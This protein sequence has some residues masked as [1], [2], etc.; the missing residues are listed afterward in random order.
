MHAREDRNTHS[1]KD[2]SLLHFTC[3]MAGHSVNFSSLEKIVIFFLSFHLIILLLLYL[4]CFYLVP[5]G[6]Q[7]KRTEVLENKVDRMLVSKAFFEW[8]HVKSSTSEGR[9]QCCSS[10][11]INLTQ[12]DLWQ[13]VEHYTLQQAH[14]TV[15]LI[16]QLTVKTQLILQDVIHMSITKWIVVLCHTEQYA[17][18]GLLQWITFNIQAIF[19]IFKWI[20]SNTFCNINSY[21]LIEQYV[22]RKIWWFFPSNLSFLDINSKRCKK[23][24]MLLVSWWKW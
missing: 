1:N 11:L 9:R 4:I 22:T 8:T 14:I 19:N 16:M 7:E 5:K 21:S 23:C 15:L 18:H 6:V 13:Y 12:C 17:M 24:T 3:L 20:K 10:F 2:Q